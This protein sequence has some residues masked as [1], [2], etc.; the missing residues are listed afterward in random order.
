MGNSAVFHR[1]NPL[2]R[3]TPQHSLQVRS[4]LSRPQKEATVAKLVEG[5][6]NSACVFGVRYK[7][8]SVKEFQAFRRSLPEPSKII[9]AKN[10][11]M[12]VAAKQ[13]DGWSALEAAYQ[14]ENAWVFCHEDVLG[15]TVKA[16]MQFE[17]KLKEKLPKDQRAAAKPTDI[18]GGVLDGKAVDYASV[19][20]LEKLPTKLELIATIA[21]LIKQVPTKVAVSIKQVPTKLAVGVKQLSEGDD[22]TSKVVGDIFPKASES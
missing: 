19:L 7:G 6:E 22:D 16:Y 8:V 12:E 5:L 1:R 20:R 3:Q 21:R 2:R 18:S 17:K 11:L 9:V 14:D 4:A 13:V 15:D 10:T